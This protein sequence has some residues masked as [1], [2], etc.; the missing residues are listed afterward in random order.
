MIDNLVVLLNRDGV[1]T[2]DY[3]DDICILGTGM[4]ELVLLDLIQRALRRAFW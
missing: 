1:R 3:A 2:I 4:Y